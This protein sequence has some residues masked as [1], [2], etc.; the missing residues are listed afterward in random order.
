M[1]GR[2]QVGE[3][4]ELWDVVVTIYRPYAGGARSFQWQSEASWPCC[5]SKVH[6]MMENGCQLAPLNWHLKMAPNL[7][8]SGHLVAKPEEVWPYSLAC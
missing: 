3:A 4:G 5:R 6:I 2:C 7:N 1:G 8:R